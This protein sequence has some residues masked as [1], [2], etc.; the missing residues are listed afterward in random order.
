MEAKFLDLKDLSRQRPLFALPNDGK[1]SIGYRFVPECSYAQESHLFIFFLAIFL[2]PR[3]VEIQTFCHQGN[4]TRWLLL[5]I[6]SAINAAVDRVGIRQMDE[7]R[8]A[9][10]CL[11]CRHSLSWLLWPQCTLT[12]ASGPF[13]SCSK[14]LFQNEAYVRSYWYENVF[15]L[16]WK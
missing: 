12:L 2:G 10:G 4:V 6:E 8:G 14:L 15:L 3:F 1:R 7:V 9:G 5:S 13:P 11:P 16:S